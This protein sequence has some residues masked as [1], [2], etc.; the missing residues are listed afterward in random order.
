M[1][2]SARAFVNPKIGKHP[3]LF[4]REETTVVVED[5]RH[6]SPGDLRQAAE[7]G[8]IDAETLGE[9]EDYRE[10]AD[11]D[12]S[13]DAL[14]ADGMSRVLAHEVARP[15]QGHKGSE[16][17]FADELRDLD[18]EGRAE[19]IK[20][21]VEW[22]QG[23]ATGYLEYEVVNAEGEVAE[24]QWDN[25]QQGLEDEGYDHLLQL[26]HEVV[27]FDEDE[28]DSGELMDILRDP[29]MFTASLNG[30][31]DRRPEGTVASWQIGDV[32]GTCDGAKSDEQ[33]YAIL[34]GGV[35]ERT[36]HETGKVA[37][38]VTYPGLGPEDIAEA[39]KELE[40]NEPYV[41]VKGVKAREGW[42]HRRGSE[43]EITA[44]DFDDSFD[45]SIG[46]Y[47]SDAVVFY[48]DADK[49]EE[50]LG[51]LE[52]STEPKAPP[53]VVY[54]YGG[55][56]DYA[57][58][59]SARGMYVA[60][61]GAQHLREES[62]MLGHCIGSEQ[63]GHP[64]ALREGKTR[65]YSIRTEAGKAKFTVELARRSSVPRPENEAQIDG[66]AWAIAEVK[67]KAN[68]LAGFEPGKPEM[69]KPDDVRLLTEFLLHLGFQPSAIRAARDTA[70]GVV[71]MEQAGVDPFLPPPKR[72]RPGKPAE[73]PRGGF[74][75]TSRVRRLLEAAGAHDGATGACSVVNPGRSRS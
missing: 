7:A 72:V 58:G 18:A 43:V 15:K 44:D 66:L 35:W 28:Y 65:V 37:E 34:H 36:D 68:R 62:K 48:Y 1:S 16:Q 60:P 70:P 47:S 74:P 24:L 49:L 50:A 38:T 59:A 42:R 2:H 21:F 69:T 11:A 30:Q 5:W 39:L 8:E 25:F 54:R 22:I 40:N 56:N 10:Q 27:E 61:L 14:L 73:N 29:G 64:K 32:Y 9:I 63:H 12:G 3:S 71:A 6:A 19:H 23:A 53:E 67:G 31:Y 41:S 26:A 46:Q 20:P 52:T 45:L 13:L 17:T 33:L 55:T 51:G 75:I 4:E 57:G